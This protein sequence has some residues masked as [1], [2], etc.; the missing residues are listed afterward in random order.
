MEAD[1][2]SME[3]ISEIVVAVES[4]VLGKRESIFFFFLICQIISRRR[5][6]FPPEWH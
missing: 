1:V 2:V 4:G 6:F 5:G 3:E